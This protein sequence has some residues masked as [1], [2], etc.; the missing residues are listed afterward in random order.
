M[1]EFYLNNL[2]IKNDKRKV[3]NMNIIMNKR[4]IRINKSNLMRLISKGII[5]R[6]NIAKSGLYYNFTSIPFAYAKRINLSCDLEVYAEDKWNFVRNM[7]YKSLEK[8]YKAPIKKKVIKHTPTTFIVKDDAFIIEKDKSESEDIKN[9]EEQI[10]EPQ[11]MEISDNDIIIDTIET[12][13]ELENTEI[14]KEID[15]KEEKESNEN[16]D[17]VDNNTDYI[18]TIPE[19]SNNDTSE[20]IDSEL[21]EDNNIE[22]TNTEEPH[23][24]IQQHDF[25]FNKPVFKNKK[26]KKK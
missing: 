11:K 26:R 10:I 9:I 6:R 20:E 5:D 4:N 16:L 22:E 15:N 18:D 8:W 21:E 2:K 1:G 25:V 19:D 3:F 12:K 13:E 7:D 24:S 14:E 17:I 23:N